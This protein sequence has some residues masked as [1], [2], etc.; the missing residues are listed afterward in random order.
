MEDK[1]TKDMNKDM[2]Q[3]YETTLE[4]A[5]EEGLELPEETLEGIAGGTTPIIDAF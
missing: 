3:D 4:E 5:K 1:T 2:A